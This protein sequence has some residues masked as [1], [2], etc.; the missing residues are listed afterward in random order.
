M[1][2]EKS[3]IQCTEHG[4]KSTT[5]VCQHILQSL[6]DKIPCG[7]F[8]QTPSKDDPRPDAWCGKC[9]TMVTSVGEWNDEVAAYVDLRGLCSDCYDIAKELNSKY[10]QKD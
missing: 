6:C 1:R 9:E 2:E 7:F 3:Y 5:I 4:R 8:T 10:P